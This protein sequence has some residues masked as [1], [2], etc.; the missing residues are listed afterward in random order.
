[1]KNGHAK[2]HQLE[3]GKV[4]SGEYQSAFSSETYHD[5]FR[6]DVFNALATSLEVVQDE[7][8]RQ[9][10]GLAEDQVAAMIHKRK[11]LQEFYTKLGVSQK[12]ISKL[13]PVI[14]ISSFLDLIV[15]T[16]TG[17]LVALGLVAKGW[18]ME[19]CTKHFNELCEEAFEPRTQGQYWGSIGTLW[20][21][22]NHSK[23]KTKP[24]EKALKKAYCSAVRGNDYVFGGTNTSPSPSTKLAVVTTSI[25]G[26]SVVISNYNRA[27]TENLTYKFLRQENPYNELE[28]WEVLDHLITPTSAAPGYFRSF[29][30]T[31]TNVI[32]EDGGIYHNNPV[33][34][35]DS[36]RKLIWPDLADIPPDIILS[37]GTGHNPNRQ[38]EQPNNPLISKPPKRGL[39]T[40]FQ[41]FK[42]IARDHVAVSLD[43]ERTWM[44]WLHTVSRPTD[45]QKRFL[46]LNV[47]CAEGPPLLDDIPSM[48]QLRKYVQEQFGVNQ[49]IE[50]VAYQL[51]AS[52]FFV[53]KTAA[54]PG[55]VQGLGHWLQSHFVTKSHRPY[56]IVRNTNDRNSSRKI[57]LTDDVLQV[58][59]KSSNFSLQLDNISLEPH[60]QIDILFCLEEHSPPREY[61]ISGFPRSLDHLLSPGTFYLSL[62][63]PGTILPLKGHRMSTVPSRIASTGSRAPRNSGRAPISE[64]GQLRRLTS[65]ENWNPLPVSW[66][67]KS[68]LP[69][70]VQDVHWSAST[71][72][73]VLEQQNEIYELVD[74]S[75]ELEN[76]NGER[77]TM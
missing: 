65:I 76:L 38:T 72:S 20:D 11:T 34:I 2:G 14:P 1:M 63:I 19:T 66:L 37:I 48:P 75:V 5:T 26:D 40:H 22:Y 51:I 21:A 62:F 50:Q 4:Y 18:T 61:M 59:V 74:T 46:R 49:S 36:E 42:R 67:D 41:T 31:N 6:A 32:Y 12:A 10:E 53:A 73:E 17:G 16:S 64:L 56:F 13:P 68:L 9:S 54:F 47:T 28:I 35:A 39:V 27:S 23:Y 45:Y 33:N 77:H 7:Q 25:S 57:S 8:Q 52:S 71:W 3:N 24:L 69:S 55:E 15:G 44:N 70:G 58:M 43:S 30:H 60:T 29:H